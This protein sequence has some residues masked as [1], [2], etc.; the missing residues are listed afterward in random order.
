METI[1]VIPEDDM[2]TSECNHWPSNISDEMSV[3][4]SDSN[5][6]CVVQLS[7]N[8]NLDYIHEI[9]EGKSIF[10]PSKTKIYIHLASQNSGLV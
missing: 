1:V 2:D 3:L 10:K 8:Q 4:I 9:F 7:K 5:S 6:I